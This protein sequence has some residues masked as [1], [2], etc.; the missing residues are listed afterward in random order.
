M[1]T[2]SSTFRSKVADMQHPHLGGFISISFQILNRRRLAG[3]SALDSAEVVGSSIIE[4]AGCTSDRSGL[5][6]LYVRE[7]S[8]SSDD[9][10]AVRHMPTAPIETSRKAP[11]SAR[12]EQR[13]GSSDVGTRRPTV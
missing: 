2:Y 5:G 4:A 6:P 1:S 11:S 12:A 8:R 10:V 7:D 13:T 9:L 3:E